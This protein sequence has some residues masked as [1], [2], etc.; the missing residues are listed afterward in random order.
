MRAD[1]RRSRQH[2]KRETRRP[3]I[4]AD[5]WRVAPWIAVGVAFLVRWWVLRTQPWVTVDGTEYIRLADAF[6]HGTSFRSVFPPGYPLLIALSH[7]FVPDRVQAAALVSLALGSLLPLPVWALARRVLPAPWALAPLAIAVLHPTL[8]GL[9]TVTMSDATYVTA[10]FAGLALAAADRPLAA[11][12][13]MGFAYATRP[14]GLLP[15]AVTVLVLARARGWN[16]AAR[17]LAGVLAMS[18]PCWLYFHANWG[19]WTLSPKLGVFPA[20]PRTWQAQ[21][22]LLRVTPAGADTTSGMLPRAIQALGGAPGTALVQLRSLLELWPIPLLA[23]SIWGLVLRRGIES[24]PLLY[25]VLV[26]FLGLPEQRRFLVSLVPS[27]AIA[28]AVGPSRVSVRAVRLAAAALAVA[29]VVMCAVPLWP[30]I[31]LPFDTHEQAQQEAGE[32]LSGVSDPADAV[33]DRKPYVAFYADRPY[34]VMPSGTYEE[35]V[36][37]AVQTGVRFL[38]L[39]E[40]VVRVFRPELLPLLH[41]AQFRAHENRLEGVYIGGRFHGHAIAIFRVLRPGETKTGRPPVTNV[42]WLDAPRGPG[43]PAPSLPR[44]AP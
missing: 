38:A 17:A 43:I 41:D 30:D 40:A 27:L 39:D 13:A 23:L 29:G 8:V 44:R 21:E 11:G 32:W 42:H 14:E 33:M 24:I 35:I 2:R 6:A 28:A 22:A 5:P 26:P 34:R 3:A 36:S 16:A 19:G 12:L 4:P 15:A 18:I 1:P 25:L 20:P 7:L 9:S 10:L 31:L 37:S